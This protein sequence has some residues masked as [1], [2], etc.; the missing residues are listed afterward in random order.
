MPEPTSTPTSEPAHDPQ[1][2][3][4]RKRLHGQFW[5]WPPT[6]EAPWHAELRIEGDPAPRRF[7]HPGDLLNFLTQTRGAWPASGGL[8]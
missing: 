7:E 4:E 1:H 3:T 5:V 8:R 6:T 2:A